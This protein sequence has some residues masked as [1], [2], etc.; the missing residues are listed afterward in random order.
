MYQ[1]G[2]KLDI[3]PC[4]GPCPRCSG[5]ASS[6]FPRQWV[7]CGFGAFSAFWATLAF[8]LASPAFGL[9]V[10]ATG[11]FGI[12]GAPGALLAPNG[13]R[14]ADRVGPNWVN[15]GALLCAGLGLALAG[16][17]GMVSVLA[18]M[19][20]ANCLDFGVQA[21]QV[22]NQ[23]RIFALPQI[24][25]ARLN[26]VYMVGVFSGGAFGSMLGTAAWSV[27]GWRGVCL[28]AGALIAVAV[29]VLLVSGL[30][31]PRKA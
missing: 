16:T 10:A 26:T 2:R 13:G 23:V 7:F 17:F 4:C 18:L 5:I 8:H 27:A 29:A 24:I 25:R 28:G 6:A 9:G 31:A 14:L 22:A 11:L 12:W 1:G 3:L 19:L 20:A 15:L 30:T 21:S